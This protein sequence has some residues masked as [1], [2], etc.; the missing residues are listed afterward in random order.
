MNR[1]IYTD[2][3]KNLD[4]SADTLA[5]YIDWLSNGE[6]GDFAD[7]KH[8]GTREVIVENLSSGRYALYGEGGY[9]TATDDVFKAVWFLKTGEYIAPNGKVAITNGS[10]YF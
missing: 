5:M 2:S 4:L 9:L 8:N 6:E 10:Y 7:Y 3:E 1:T